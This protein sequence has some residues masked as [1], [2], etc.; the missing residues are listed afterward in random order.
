MANPDRKKEILRNALLCAVFLLPFLVAVI[1]NSMADTT[2]SGLP[3][4]AQVQY[5]YEHSSGLTG[6]EPTPDFGATQQSTPNEAST[7]ATIYPTH[8]A[9]LES[10]PPPLPTPTP[11]PTQPPLPTPTP[12]PLSQSSE[13]ATSETPS[14]QA[15]PSS[16]STASQPGP[17]PKGQYVESS[18]E[19]ENRDSETGTSGEASERTNGEATAGTAEI[20]GEAV[21]APESRGMPEEES[22]DEPYSDTNEEASTKRDY[23]SP[24]KVA[25][26]TID[27]G[28]SRE[29]TPGILDLLKQ[30]GIKATFFVLPHSGVSDIYRR[31]I[32]EGHEM[33]NHSYSH[34]Y[35]KLYNAKDIDAFKDDALLAREFIFENF[36]YLTTSYRFPGGAMSWKKSIIE[37]RREFLD[38]LGYKD[39]DWNVETGDSSTK[40]KDKSAEALAARVL[41]NTRNRDKLIVLMH[42]TKSKATTLEALPI[43]ITGLRAQGYTFDV[44]QNY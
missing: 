27:D 32:D 20:D 5:G 22:F 44:L 9:P 26:I 24:D 39:F 37:P 15:S 3:D 38:E 33:G 16:D 8:S 1:I 7:S 13:P 2:A 25:Y 23:P 29:V 28:P 30:E 12:T 41:D 40:Y 10:S 21:A 43:I 31:I 19:E 36:G 4:G 42:D 34:V 18:G 17:T 6:E 14:T 11:T 35:S